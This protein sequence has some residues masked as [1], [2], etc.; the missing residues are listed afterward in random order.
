MEVTGGALMSLFISCVV[1][2]QAQHQLEDEIYKLKRHQLE[3]IEE[4]RVDPDMVMRVKKGKFQNKPDVLLKMWTLC[5]LMKSG[6]MTPQGVY[7][8]DNAL[9]R[10]PKQD[11]ELVGKQI[12]KCLSKK[13]IPPVD[14]AYNF[15][16]C[17]N[18]IK[19]NYTLVSII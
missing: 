4:T 10:V 13:A 14:I 18:K 12:D 2:I 6:L 3:C 16:K 9:S 5:T 8:F 15:V 1:L 17:Y 11:A 7:K 19:T